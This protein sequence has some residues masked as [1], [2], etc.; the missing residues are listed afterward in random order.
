M[1]TTCFD[2]VDWDA[3]DLAM[4]GFPEMFW[5]W[6]SK[7]MSHF[8]GVDR[9]QFTCRFWDHSQ[10]PQCQQDNETTEHIILCNGHGK[11]K[12]GL[13]ESPTLGCG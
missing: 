4:A 8:Y 3:I 9:M 12:K 6:A 5:L 13:V 7:H 11:T 10:C 2:L 1:S